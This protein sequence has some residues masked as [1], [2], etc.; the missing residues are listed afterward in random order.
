M[1]GIIVCLDWSNICFRSLFSI[2]GFG[3]NYFTFKSDEEINS[4]IA[5]IGTDVAFLLR[6]FNPQ[7]VVFAADSKHSWRKDVLET[8][9]IHRERDENIDWERVFAAIDDFKE[10][11]KGLGYVFLETTNAEADDMMA[12]LKEVVFQESDFSNYN[13]II[14]SADAD[15]RQLIDWNDNNQYCMVFNE[16]GRGP[17]GKRHLYC[18]DEIL[19]WCN[20]EDDIQNDIFNFCSVDGDKEYIRNLLANNPKV[21][22]EATDP[23]NILLNK[24]FCGDDGDDV[25]A[26][27]DWYSDKGKKVRV[28]NRYYV[29]IVDALGTKDID[30]VD[31]RR[32]ELK[33]ILESATK[34]SINDINVEERYDRQKKLVQLSSHIFPEHIRLYKSNVK[35]LVETQQIM[36]CGNLQM[37]DMIK[38]SQFEKVLKPQRA[39]EADIF[40]GL[41]DYIDNH[42]LVALF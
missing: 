25:P 2:N 14:I 26:F 10:H 3:S 17:G 28:T 27:Y 23:K 4:L 42:K 24:I 13:L 30:E 36:I 29:K 8:Y 9:K 37:R 15:I 5:R 32:G 11:L 6:M 18:N 38:G 34:R 33:A 35:S 16:V 22:M 40:K 12:L 41:N 21:V 19:S 20:N 31:K 7:K 1:K 39:K